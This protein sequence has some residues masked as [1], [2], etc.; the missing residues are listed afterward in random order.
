LD[1][2]IRLEF[3]EKNMKNTARFTLL[4]IFSLAVIFLAACNAALP[5]GAKAILAPDGKS[6]QVEFTGVV[7]SIAADQWVVSGQTL[8]INAQSVIEGVLAAGDSVKVHATVTSDGAV[9]ANKIEPATNKPQVTP[10]SNVENEKDFSGVVEVISAD[11][12]QISGQVF[13]VNPQTEIKGNI[14][15]GDKVKVHF[16]NNGDGTFTAT[17]IG[18]MDDKPQ[19]AG[20]ILELTGKVEA[21]TDDAWTVKGQVFTVN[22]GT[23]IKDNILLGDVAKVHY[24]VNADGTFT[25]TEIELAGNNQAHNSEKKLTGTLQELTATQATIDGVVVLITPQTMLDSG[26]VPGVMV[27]AEV[28]TN[29][30]GT[31]TALKIEL[32]NNSKPGHEDKNGSGSG[33]GG[34]HRGGSD[35]TPRAPEPGDDHGDDQGG[36]H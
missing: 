24:V 14:L 11:S 7:E 22:T 13:I 21:F 10:G 15:V 1:E 17:E 3:K 34:S 32:F 20:G 2:T 6:A 35:G 29:P 18:L 12:W 25:A 28:V 30:D 5:A 8:L 36:G 16:L 27:K 19:D 26:L 4:G 9:T 31:I 33:S 23:T